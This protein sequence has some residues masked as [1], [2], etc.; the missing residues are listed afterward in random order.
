MPVSGLVFPECWDCPR[1]SEC[2]RQRLKMCACVCPTKYAVFPRSIVF[3]RYWIRCY[4]R[5]L[6][7]LRHTMDKAKIQYVHQRSCWVVDRGQASLLLVHVPSY[8]IYL[9]IG[10]NRHEHL[11]I[12]FSIT[13]FTF[14]WF[15]ASRTL[16]TMTQRVPFFLLVYNG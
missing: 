13:L 4:R 2:T 16:W 15:E 5:W 11:C 6:Y 14:T 9:Y 7:R 1:H 10:C 8:T 3:F 12:Y